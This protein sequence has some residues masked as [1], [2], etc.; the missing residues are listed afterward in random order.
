N[1]RVLV[2]RAAECDTRA[3]GREDRVGEQA[4]TARQH[5]RLPAAARHAPELPG[6]LE[7]D[8]RLR[9]GRMAQQ[10]PVSSPG[11]TTCEESERRREPYPHDS[12]LRRQRVE[13]LPSIRLSGV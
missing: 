13:G 1:V 3:I 9:Q 2:V 8:L 7:D 11:G 10:Q 12:D 4:H 6:V 5:V